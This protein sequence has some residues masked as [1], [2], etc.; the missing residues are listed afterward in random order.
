MDKPI[1]CMDTDEFEDL[2]DSFIAR[3][4]GED[5]RLPAQTF[6]ELLAGQQGAMEP[7]E[8][9]IDNHNR[10]LAPEIVLVP[11]GTV[12]AGLT[13]WLA[14]RLA[15]VLGQDVVV[16]KGIFGQATL[17]GREAFVALPRLRPSFYGRPEDAALYRERAL[18]ECIHEL[19]HTW[20][21]GHCADP[22]CV[23]RFSNALRDTD[24][25]GFAFCSQCQG[26][27]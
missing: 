8:I 11:I 10:A 19:G 18:K 14:N 24:A 5:D 6:F 13:A 7:V 1:G 21:L 9:H 26:R 25:K 15:G 20:G 22:R 12:S 2:I 23:M 17:N 3:R 16:E 4:S 27:L